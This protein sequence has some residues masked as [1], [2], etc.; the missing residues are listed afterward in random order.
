VRLSNHV[1]TVKA[2]LPRPPLI[3]AGWGSC[4]PVF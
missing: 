1:T 3:N 2:D 4:N